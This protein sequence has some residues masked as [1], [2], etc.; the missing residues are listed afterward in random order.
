MGN[1]TQLTPCLIVKD[2]SETAC[3]KAGASIGEEL[4][5]LRNTR[6]V[7]AVNARPMI[8]LFKLVLPFIV[9]RPPIL[10]SNAASFLR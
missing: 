10:S 3:A 6:R 4:R 7:G 1:K 2:M 9:W 8:F 5:Y